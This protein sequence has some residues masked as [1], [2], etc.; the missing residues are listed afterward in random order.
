MAADGNLVFDTLDRTIEADLGNVSCFFVGPIHDSIEISC[1]TDI[2]HLALLRDAQLILVGTER[3]G[4]FDDKQIT[5]VFRK[6]APGVY[7]YEIHVGGKVF[8]G[9]LP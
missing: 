2:D 5:W 4:S 9:T 3:T 6:I 8:S 1:W 7:F